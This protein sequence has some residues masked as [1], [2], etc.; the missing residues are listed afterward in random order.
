MTSRRSFLRKGGYG[1]LVFLLDGTRVLLSPA[2]A[3]ERA[4]PLQILSSEQAATL[5]TLGEILHPGAR[6][7][8]IAH[9]VDQQLAAPLHETMLIA[10]HF[11][12]PPFIAFYQAGLSAL[13]AF[14]TKHQGRKFATLDKPQAVAIVE[15]IRDGTPAQWVGPPAQLLYLVVRGD[16]VDVVYAGME[17]YAQLGI[18]YMPHILPPSK[19]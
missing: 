3:R 14:S 10:K 13:D 2:E 8:G 4:V 15:A 12:E 1:G 9:F 18:P 6:A 5:E 11:I 7:A 17:D 19:W 16:A